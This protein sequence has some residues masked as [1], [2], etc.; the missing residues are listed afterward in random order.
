MMIILLL[1][2]EHTALCY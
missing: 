1:E 2:L